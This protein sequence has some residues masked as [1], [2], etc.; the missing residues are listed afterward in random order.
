MDNNL[1]SLSDNSNLNLGIFALTDNDIG[2]YSP[3]ISDRN[4]VWSSYDGNDDE[5]YLYNYNKA[6][7]TQLTNNDFYDSSPQIAGN[8]VV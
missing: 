5:I 7:V 2:D 8:S 4:I 3:Q 6:T 1:N